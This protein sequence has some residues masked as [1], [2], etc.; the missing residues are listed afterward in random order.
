[1]SEFRV[2]VVQL[3]DIVKHENADTLSITHVFGGYPVIFRTGEYNTGD[4]AVYVPVDALV[5]AD[6]PRWEFLAGHARIRAKRLR[7][8]FSMGLLTQADPTWEIGRNVQ[9]ELRIQKYEPPIQLGA[10]GDNETCPFDFPVYTDIEGYRRYG[11]VLQEGEPVILTEKLH[12]ANGRFVYQDGRLWVGSHGCVKKESNTSLWWIVAKQYGLE[13]K[14]SHYPGIALYGEVYGYVQDLH[15]GLQRGTF[16]LGFFDAMELDK[17]R[18]LNVD[19]FMHLVKDELDLPTVPVLYT[20]PWS[21]TLIEQF[22]NGKSTI[23]DHIREGFVARPFQERWDDTV[24]RVILKFIGE[25]YLLR[26][27]K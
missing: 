19:D 2:E 7:G 6:D 27:E 15:Y 10:G 21:N 26:K 3:S 17:R 16:R 25:D 8:I 22:T 9:E 12:G 11:H 5:P 4:K 20:G 14:L 23:A 1:M 24:G 13:E 18:Y